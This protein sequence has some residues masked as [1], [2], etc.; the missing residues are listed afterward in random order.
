MSVETALKLLG[1][2]EGASFDDILRAKNSVVAS[3]K[4]DQES[5]AQVLFVSLRSCTSSVTISDLNASN[6]LLLLLVESCIISNLE[7]LGFGCGLCLIW[8][9]CGNILGLGLKLY[10]QNSV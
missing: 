4:D 2:S 10:L 3:C 7:L 5:I 9:Y 1:V 6:L 8:L